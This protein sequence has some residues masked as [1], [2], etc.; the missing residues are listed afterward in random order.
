[1]PVKTFNGICP[2][3]DAAVYVDDTAVI[4]G[5]VSLEKDSSVWPGAVL[6]GDVSQIRV[7]A[8][9]NVQDA[10]VF[11]TN[12]DMPVIIGREVTIG[13]GVILHG[14][15]IGDR[16]LIGMRALVL[17]GAEVPN[18]TIIGAGALVP[19]GARLEPGGVYMGLPAKRIRDIRLEEIEL[20]KRRAQEYIELSK[21]YSA[22]K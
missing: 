13:H 9:S 1:M 14:C 2:D 12:I 3:L 22:K 16:S 8:R 10:S 21:C 6:R 11:H 5:D 19:E 18:D 20:I 7:G 17:D 15:K 4:I